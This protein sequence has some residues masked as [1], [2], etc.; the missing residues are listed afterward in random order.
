MA[1]ARRQ[2]N[3]TLDT[4][5]TALGQKPCIQMHKNGAF[6]FAANENL[7]SFDA[8][9]V[10]KKITVSGSAVTFSEAGIYQAC[11]SFRSTTDVW[12]KWYVKD[13][14][15]NVLGESAW[16]GSGQN[17]PNPESWLFTIS[18]PGTYFFYYYASSPG[19]SAVAP[20]PSG[21]PPGSLVKTLSITVTKVSDL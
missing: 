5:L 7:I 20:A 11:G 16:G 12:R 18:T 15:G 6:S 4:S 13:S 14:S 9:T 8:G 10:N 21:S 2:S 1:K 17:F 19:D 3:E